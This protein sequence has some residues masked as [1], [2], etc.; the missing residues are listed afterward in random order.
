MNISKR[1][2]Y[3]FV[4]ICCAVVSFNGETLAENDGYKFNDSAQKKIDK[5]FSLKALKPVYKL[6]KDKNIEIKNGVH[7]NQL[8]GDVDSFRKIV[9][10]S[11]VTPETYRLVKLINRYKVPAFHYED[12]MAGASMLG[13]GG[14]IYNVAFYNPNPSAIIFSFGNT[15]RT[16]VENK[17][18]SFSTFSHEAQHAANDADNLQLNYFSKVPRNFDYF[19]NSKFVD[20]GIGY[21]AGGKSY[22]EC[23]KYHKVPDSGVRFLNLRNF[24]IGFSLHLNYYNSVIEINKRFKVGTP[25]QEL[26][27]GQVYAL[28]AYSTIKMNQL[29]I[30]RSEKE[31]VKDWFYGEYEKFDK[32]KKTDHK[33]FLEETK[34]NAR[35][36]WWPASS[37]IEPPEW[38]FSDAEELT[39]QWVNYNCAVLNETRKELGLP[40]LKEASLDGVDLPKFK[41]VYSYFGQ[42]AKVEHWLPYFEQK[43]RGN[44]PWF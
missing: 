1:A 11:A 10:S 28:T 12:L 37:S 41:K 21:Y 29:N 9:T 44:L 13:W 8:D 14:A 2:P 39:V 7:A 40:E 18:F 6:Y 27:D 43:T 42:E 32:L 34:G 35:P 3:I 31:S 20:E 33:K 15:F 26:T 24:N 22:F 4:G 16:V 23:L 5:E 38:D 30:A 17:C 25:D 19:F 36:S